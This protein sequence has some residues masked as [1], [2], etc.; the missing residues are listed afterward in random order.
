MVRYS[1]RR[2]AGLPPLCPPAPLGLPAMF[3]FFVCFFC[4]FFFVWGG[5][6][7]TPKALESWLALACGLSARWGTLGA[8]RRCGSLTPS[9]FRFNFTW[10]LTLSCLFFSH[11]GCGRIMAFP[12]I[13]EPGL[14]SCYLL[15]G[16]CRHC[17]QSAVQLNGHSLWGLI[18]AMSCGDLALPSV[19]V[20]SVITGVFLACAWRIFCSEP[21]CCV[22]CQFT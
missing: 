9:Q 2:V 20:R 7:G 11:V 12:A 13:I 16:P 1:K 6:S 14:L 22:N 8:A 21:G 19:S 17:G 4:L 10:V 5:V 18:K 15:H 3:I